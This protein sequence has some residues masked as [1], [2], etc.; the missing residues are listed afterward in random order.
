MGTKTMITRVLSKHWKIPS[1]KNTQNCLHKFFSE[2]DLTMQCWVFIF[3]LHSALISDDENFVYLLF[4]TNC[5]ENK[6]PDKIPT[7]VILW[8]GNE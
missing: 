6:I 5:S 7:P 8:N 1:V 4:Q 2:L 3:A